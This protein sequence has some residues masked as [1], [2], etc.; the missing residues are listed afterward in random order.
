MT[1][2]STD[3][4]RAAGVSRTTVSYI[5]NGK[6]EQFTEKTRKLV[7][8]TAKD[9]GYRPVAAA[10]T[11]ARGSSNVI[12][13]LIPLSP[14]VEFM[15]MMSQ[16]AQRLSKE[17]QTLLMMP[18]AVSAK[19][20]E[21]TVQ[22]V[23]PRL[24][25]AETHLTPAQRKVLKKA[26]TP[27][28]DVA[29]E[30]SR[31]GGMNWRI[32]Q[33]QAE[34]LSAC[35]ITQLVYARLSTAENDVIQKARQ[36]GFFAKCDELGLPKP[37]TVT[38]NPQSDLNID[39]MRS[40]KK[41]AGIACYND[42]TAAAMLGAGHLIGLSAPDDFAIIGVDNT[43]IALQTDP[44]LSTIATKGEILPLIDTLLSIPENSG[45]YTTCKNPNL[46]VITRG[47]TKSGLA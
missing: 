18:P 43:T 29:A 33:L 24:F 47:T 37:V 40:L 27:F 9:L 6:G 46:T 34:H 21:Y 32:G 20:L 28:V 2:T 30:T 11:L 31:K 36:A 5:L 7:K 12:L 3:V 38:V 16:L 35:G 8:K 4:A 42:D 1:V 39:I 10:Q 13:T 17:S 14:N 44:Q 15:A 25:L 19:D 22:T 45:D 23:R 26:K 41:H